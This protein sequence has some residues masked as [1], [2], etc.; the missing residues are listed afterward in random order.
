ML[1]TALK[2]LNAPPPQEPQKKT[3]TDTARER[4]RRKKKRRKQRKAEIAANQKN[5]APRESPF[6]LVDKT[7][8][9]YLRAHAISVK[10]FK[11]PVKM[12]QDKKST[13]K[14]KI[15]A[16]LQELTGLKWSF[17][18][19][20]DFFKDDKK[21]KGTFYSNQYATLSADEIDSFFGEATSAIVQKIEKFT[22]EGS[23]W[24]IDKCNTLFLNIAKYE[25]LKGSSYIPLPEVLAHKKAIINVKNK[26]QECLRWTLRSAFFS[27]KNN[28]N[29]P[30]SYP[31]QDNLNMEGIDFPTPIPQINKIERQNNIALN[32][33]GYERA[34]VPYHISG[35]PTE[36]PRINLLLLHDKQDNYHYCWIK[37]LSRL[38]FDQNKHKGKTYFCDRCLYGFS[39]EDL[40]INHKDECYGINDRATKIQMP[41]PGE[42]IKF[43]NY[44]K[45]MQV[46][47]VIYADFESIIK[48]YQA[49]A[50]DKS[51]I[52]SKHQACGFGYQ[53]V[54]YDGAS[55]NVRIYRGEDAGEQFLKS[56]HQEVININAIFAKPKPLHMSE[57]NEKDFQSSTQCWICQKEFNDEKIQRLEITVIS[58][59]NTEVQH[60][61]PATQNLL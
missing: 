27:A 61:N 56:L 51:E 32:V 26:D 21:I 38:L 34:V 50:G 44:H 52:K 4:R 59:A 23:G 57:K 54:R 60:T 25:P 14:T 35:Q 18:L 37:H 13:I 43:K 11:D 36:M 7:K 12:F 29:T 8:C 31:K 5:E 16:E 42:K 58:W 3:L 45:Q 46:P 10:R 30:Y 53:I 55:S 33:Y 41:A 20:V 47:F 40:L 6:Q 1:N 19:T 9:G 39:R 48:P 28:L 15:T 17:G 2:A 49:A 24:M 22:K